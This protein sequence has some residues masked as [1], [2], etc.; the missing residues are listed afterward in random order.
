MCQLNIFI[1]HLKQMMSEPDKTATGT[2]LLLECFL[3]YEKFT[4]T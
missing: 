3:H 2:V 4:D 1:T